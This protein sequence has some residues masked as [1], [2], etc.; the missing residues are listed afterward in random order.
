MVSNRTP[1]EE[2][3][4]NG[5]WEG[6]IN[7]PDTGTRRFEVLIEVADKGVTGS[8]KTWRGSIQLGSP[9]RDITFSRGT[10]RFTIDLQGKVHRFEGTLE[11]NSI[12]GTATR[13]GRAPASFTL[14]YAE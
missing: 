10:V 9:L 1:R 6:N 7:D 11:D 3:A 2:V 4:I 12:S 13:E 14:E 5:R 8:M